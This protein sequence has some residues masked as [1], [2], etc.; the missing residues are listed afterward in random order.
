[1]YVFIISVPL[2]ISCTICSVC[3]FY[4]AW[5]TCTIDKIE[6][7]SETLFC[8]CFSLLVFTETGCVG[9]GCK[10]SELGLKT[11][12]KVGYSEH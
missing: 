2:G 7:C 4:Q 11:A 6:M 3:W 10:Q 12:A 5:I 8:K 9:G 1:M